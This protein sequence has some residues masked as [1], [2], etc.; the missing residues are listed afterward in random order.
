MDFPIKRRSLTIN[1]VRTSISL[2]EPFWLR[3][4]EIARERGVPLGQLVHEIDLR[5]RHTNLS[6]A[7]RQVIA[8]DCHRRLVALQGQ[9][10]NAT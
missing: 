1:G 4:N 5:R 8:E 2:E 9:L 7:I 3:L 10:P 6:A